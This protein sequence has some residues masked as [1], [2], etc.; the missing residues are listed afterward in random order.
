MLH[1]LLENH[2]KLVEIIT[3]P[4]LRVLKVG[5]SFISSIAIVESNRF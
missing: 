1:K 3:V 5:Y 4:V 2:I